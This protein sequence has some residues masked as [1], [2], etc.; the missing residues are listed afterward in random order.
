MR[1]PCINLKGF[2][3]S[4]GIDKNKT[5]T[6]AAWSEASFSFGGRRVLGGRGGGS[7]VHHFTRHIEAK[8]VDLW[9]SGYVG[10]ARHSRGV[11]NIV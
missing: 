9:W 11:I 3:K 10:D 1:V 2:K 4:V 5:G 6:T 7:I 8:N